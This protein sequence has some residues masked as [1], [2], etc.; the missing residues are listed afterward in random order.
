MLL[1]VLLQ[2]IVAH[3]SV[4]RVVWICIVY[5]GRAALAIFVLRYV[6]IMHF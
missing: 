4:L 1:L 5:R 6:G 2:H 3:L